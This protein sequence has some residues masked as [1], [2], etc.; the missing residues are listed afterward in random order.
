[1]SDISS[2]LDVETTEEWRGLE[3]MLSGGRLPQAL[4]AILPVGS[5][6]RFRDLFARKMLCSSGTGGDSCAGCLGWTADGHP[7][8]VVAGTWGSPPGVEECLAFQ[9]ALQLKPVL[10]LRR[11]GVVSCSDELSLPAANSLLKLAEE[12]PEGVH[13]LFLA[14]RDNIIPTIRS[15]TWSVAFGDF[16]SPPRD[17]SPPPSEPAEW[18]AWFESAKKLAPAEVAASADSWADWFASRGEWMLAAELKNLSYMADKRHM[19]SSMIQDALY[20]VLREGVRVEEI[21]G[22][23]RET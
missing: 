20:A 23:L 17:P 16:G 13:I 5:W 12:P 6:E 14:G 9:A 10:A 3:A 22:D 2:V 4:R 11:L 1:M 7:D 19:P 21:F 15:R 18:A 8:L